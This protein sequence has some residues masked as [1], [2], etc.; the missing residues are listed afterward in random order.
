MESAHN[1]TPDAQNALLKILEEPPPNATILLGATNPNA[2]L[3]TVLS[4]CELIFS[5]GEGEK[6]EKPIDIAKFLSLDLPQQFTSIE[7]TTDKKALLHQLILYYRSEFHKKPADY[8]K[9][10]MLL[11]AEEWSAHNVNTRAIL[12]YLVLSLLH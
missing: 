4:R 7:K 9:M 1:F 12:E 2:F 8:K 3:P 10:Q 6:I 11:E 5:T